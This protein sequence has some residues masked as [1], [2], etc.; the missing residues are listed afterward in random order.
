M[1]RLSAYRK[2]PNYKTLTYEWFHLLSYNDSVA[3][4]DLLVRLRTQFAQAGIADPQLDAELLTGA[5]LDETRGRVQSLA[6]LGSHIDAAKAERI[7]ELAAERAARVPLQH[8]TG[9]AHFRHLELSVGPGVFIPRPETETVAQLAID[10]LH[11]DASAEPRALDLCAGSGAIALAMA[12]EVDRA[13]VWA[14]EKDEQ[15][16]AWTTR[17]V[18]ALG[19]GR[20]TLIHGDITEAH[21]ELEEI[22]GTL[23]VI[24]ANPPYVPAHAIPKDPEVRDHDPAL[25]LYSGDDGLT[26]IRSISRR[27]RRFLR[28]GGLIVIEHAEMQGDAVRAILARDGWQATATHRDLTLRDRATTARA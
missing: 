19:D 9:K 6:V 15:A 3:V 25:A 13:R 16:H 2:T 27:Y 20:V 28:P 26:L 22:A 7:L 23:S 5:V 12:T 4:N 1:A 18:D 17:N 21:P 10:E 14:V 24:A 11:A 8:L